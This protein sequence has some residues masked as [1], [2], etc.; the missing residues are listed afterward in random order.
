MS[1]KRIEN[2][3]FS[4]SQVLTLPLMPSINSFLCIIPENF[5]QKQA[6]LNTSPPV[7]LSP[8]SQS[9]RSLSL[10]AIS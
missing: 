9:H 7:G 1:I 8:Y 6:Y 10:F 3:H 5:A 4:L 2:I